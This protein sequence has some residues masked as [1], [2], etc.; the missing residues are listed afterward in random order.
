MPRT[1][2]D[3]NLGSIVCVKE[4]KNDVDYILV[5]KDENGC[6]LMRKMCMEKGSNGVPSGVSSSTLPV[7]FNQKMDKWFQEGFLSFFDSS[8]INCMIERSVTSSIQNGTD[9]I[10]ESNQNRKAYLPSQIILSN[11]DSNYVNALKIAYDTNSINDAIKT[12]TDKDGVSTCSYWTLTV[13]ND[14]TF[15]RVSSTGLFKTDYA[16][17]YTAASPRPIINFKGSVAV[18]DQSSDPT[19]RIYLLPDIISPDYDVDDTEFNRLCEDILS[20]V[21]GEEVRGSIVSA[22]RL[23]Y[24]DVIKT[25]INKGLKGNP[26]KSAY[27]I[28]VSKGYS[29]TEKQWVESLK[30][31]TK[32]DVIAIVREY[33]GEIENGYY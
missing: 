8:L 30:G 25:I 27:E 21:F 14:I 6:E 29:G 17:N 13:Y 18:S 22:L 20:A 19:E 10:S 33:M 12:V 26:G 28:A 16:P 1:L 3:L 31:Q 23:C 4:N 24:S 9:M 2:N 15:Y 5:N 7:Y 32:E 11:E